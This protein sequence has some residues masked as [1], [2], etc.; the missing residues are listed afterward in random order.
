MLFL[1]P[2]SNRKPSNI[3]PKKGNLVLSY[4]ENITQTDRKWWGKDSGGRLNLTKFP[5]AQ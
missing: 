5:E 2:K 1:H 3:S 4:L